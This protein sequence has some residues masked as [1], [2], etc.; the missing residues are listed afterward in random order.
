MRITLAS[1]LLAGLACFA[2]QRPAMP[3][4]HPVR[5]E[6]DRRGQL[7]GLADAIGGRGGQAAP[8]PRRNFIDEQIFGKMQ[9]DRIPHAPLA[10]DEEFFRRVHLDLTGRIGDAAEL[11]KFAADQSA[12]KR[13]KLI[14]SLLGSAAYKARWTYW[15]ADLSMTAANRVGNEG[16]NLYYKWVYDQIH[17][18][19]PYNEMVKDLLTASAS[20]NWYVGP[21]SY[22]ARWVVIGLQCEDEVHEDTSD[23]LAIHSFKHFLGVDLSC[24]SC[25]DGAKHLEKISVWHTARKRS[26]LWQAAAFFGNTRILRRTEIATTRDEYSI[27]DEGEGYDASARTVVRIPRNGKGKVEP[28]FPLTGEKPNLQRPLRSEFARLLTNHPQFARAAVN[29]FWAEMMGVGIVDPPFDFDLARQ[30]PKS[31]P[32]GWDLQPTHPELLEELAADFR[33][34]NYDLQHLL[35]TITQSSAYQLSARFPGEW[36]QSYANY[37]ARRFVRRLT[38]EQIHDSL[39]FATNLHTVVPIR[40]N[41][42][43]RARY[44]TETRSPEDLRQEYPGLKDMLFFLDSFGQTNREYSERT[45]DGDVTQ[46]ALLMNSPFVLNQVKHRPGSYLSGLLEARL[47]QEETIEKLFYRFLLRAPSPEELRMARQITAG[48]AAKSYE[49]LQW[50]L[51]NK[52]EFLFNY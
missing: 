52:V 5:N 51:V 48:G 33:K 3:E 7:A 26:E 14:D 11:R 37:F 35:R 13:D 24:V 22:L 15:F 50:L 8:V 19:W 25:H 16:K 21:A 6:T 40:G 38:A 2:Q 10:S 47:E 29:L 36:K 43:I 32:A 4:G 49:D 44:A 28:V 30:D 23:E 45:N 17:L 42:E 20:S 27:D 41:S 1:M 18:N 12:D 46:A 9:R 39:V 31:L 34:H